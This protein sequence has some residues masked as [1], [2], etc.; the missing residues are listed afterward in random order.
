MLKLRQQNPLEFLNRC[1]DAFVKTITEGG[2]LTAVL[3]IS[4]SAQEDTT[5]LNVAISGNY[6]SA[7]GRAALKTQ[8]Q[9][10]LLNR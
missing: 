9:T 4:T 7:E 8:L 3:D 1:G 2:E 6:G 10:T 5:N